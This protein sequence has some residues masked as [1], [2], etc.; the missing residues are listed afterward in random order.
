ME[1]DFLVI[2]SGIAGLTF[3][4]KAA[5]HGTVAIIT[6]RNRSES[7]TYY[8]QGGIA[9]VLGSDDTFSDHMADTVKAGAGLCHTDIVQMVVSDGPARIDE[10]LSLGARFTM[11]RSNGIEKLAMGQEGGHSKRRI[12]HAKDITGRE[13]E[14]A[15][16]RTIER[17][18]NI[19][20]F[21]HHISVD[22]ITSAKFLS[23][24]KEDRCMG[25]YVMNKESGEIETFLARITVVA[26]GGAGKAYL[27]TSNP[28]VATGDGIAMAYRAGASVANMEFIQFHPTCLYHPDAK[29]FLITEAVR[30]EG[31]ILRTEDGTPFM[32][33]HHRDREL[34]PRDVVARAIDFELKKSGADCV[35]LDISHKPSDF[36][37]SRFPNI[38]ERC[39][40]FDIDITRESIPIVPAAHY[41]CGGIVT[42]SHGASDISGLF[43]IGESASTGL[44]GANRLASNSLLE[45]LVF[46]DRAAARSVELLMSDRELFPPIPAWKSGKAV[47][48]DEAVVITQNWDEIRRFMWHYV[49]I[50]RSN[51]RLERA[52]RRIENLKAEINDYYWDF[53]ITSD[54]IELRNLSVVAELIIRSA[55]LRKE[56]RG[57]HYNIDY[58]ERDDEQWQ[59]DTVLKA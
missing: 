5:R 25:A 4:L 47:D 55:I 1:S 14:E 28:D 33:Q 46:A 30:G 22:L 15:L 29:A 32:E 50:V 34:A 7:A 18:E 43:A 9:S 21:E 44:H 12:V 40:E 6:K 48:S 59:K 27:V 45:A 13:V 39:L 24:V 52:L 41:T 19:T 31:G 3:A 10:L 11:E 2:G 57:L 56:S 51:R 16:L 49:G 26:T 35:Y 38:Y 8:A 58:P 36:I 20:L 23:P 42:D 54:L 37:K 53:T 17:E